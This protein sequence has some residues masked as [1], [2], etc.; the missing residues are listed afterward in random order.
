MAQNIYHRVL[1]NYE[2]LE[3]VMLHATSF[4]ILA[5]AKV[6]RY[7]REV[8]EGSKPLRLYLFRYQPLPSIPIRP[9]LA[10]GAA[11]IKLN[12]PGSQRWHFRTKASNGVIFVFRYDDDEV[13][14]CAPASPRSHIIVFDGRYDRVATCSVSR[15]PNFVWSDA[16]GF[17]VVR[18][19][20]K[21]ATFTGNSLRSYLFAH[22]G[23]E[24]AAAE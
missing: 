21:P 1:L 5:A 14:M 7:W 18:T 9:P 13:F 4:E 12:R 8:V 22:C 24:F 10:I 11:V 20:C 3:N 16:G 6:C 19:D 2:L 15:V 17:V 23:D